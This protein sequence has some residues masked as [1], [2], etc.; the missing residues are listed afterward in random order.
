MEPA[1]MSVTENVYRRHSGFCN[2]FLHPF[3]LCIIQ[4]QYMAISIISRILKLIALKICMR[5]GIYK[6]VTI[7]I[8]RLS[9]IRE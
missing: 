4:T 1:S 7:L 8:L 3:P 9:R 6:Q 5:N 2:I